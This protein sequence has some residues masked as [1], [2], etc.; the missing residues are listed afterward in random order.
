MCNHW[1]HT[2]W[3]EWK[4]LPIVSTVC[5]HQRSF[6][7]AVAIMPA[8]WFGAAKV[9][10]KVVILALGDI[11]VWMG[12]VWFW[13]SILDVSVQWIQVMFSFFLAYE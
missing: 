13:M 5:A 11:E 6:L 2:M 9:K 1:Q 3:G 4:V 7:K 8:L 12:H 10:F